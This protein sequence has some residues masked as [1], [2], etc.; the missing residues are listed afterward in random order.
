MAKPLPDSAFVERIY[1][2]GLNMARTQ[3]E[4]RVCTVRKATASDSAAI[5]ECLRIAF[6]PYR[7]HYTP[8]AIAD[9]TLT[10]ETLEVRFSTMCIL[11]STSDAGVIGTVAYGVVDRTEGHIRGM[12][13]LPA[14]QGCGVAEQLLIAVESELR[15]R[16]CSRISLDTTEPLVPAIR[17]YEKH[18]FRRSGKVGDFFGMPLIEYVRNLS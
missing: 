14:W 7:G 18:G 2:P 12:A 3:Y 10:P 15:G 13:V 16:K 6:E 8:E 5:L 1:L 4:R 11:V 9:T 17:F